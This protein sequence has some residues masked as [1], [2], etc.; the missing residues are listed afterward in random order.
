[1][2]APQDRRMRLR[3]QRLFQYKERPFLGFRIQCERREILCG[4]YGAPHR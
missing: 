1:M 4:L 2:E 3:M